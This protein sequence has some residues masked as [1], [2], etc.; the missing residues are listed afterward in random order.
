MEVVVMRTADGVRD[1]RRVRSW[2]AL[3]GFVVA[4]MVAV[5]IPAERATAASDYVSL[6]T[7]LRL[8]DTRPGFDTID[9]HQAGIGMRPAGS[10]RSMSG[11]HGKTSP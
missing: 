3:A 1:A 8:V 5:S 9:G 7:P 2:F 6:G 10:L 11:K 4:S